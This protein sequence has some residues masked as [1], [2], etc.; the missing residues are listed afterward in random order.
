[1]TIL[2]GKAT[3]AS[4]KQ[5]LKVEIETLA[6]RF[7]RA[8]K[9]AAVLLGNDGASE[10]YVGAKVRSCKEIGIESLLIRESE[11]ISEDELLLIVNQLNTDDAVDGILV[12]LPLPKHINEERIT[13]AIAPIKDVDGFHPENLG[14]LVLGV[15]SY[16]PATPLGIMM[17][18]SQY[19]I[20]TE[21]MHAVVIGR[22]AIV[23]TP[24]SL[25]L[26]R[27][28][29]PGNCTVTLAHSR[30]KNL[31]ELTLQADLIIAALGK[32]EFLT[33]DM[34]KNGAVVIDV[35]ITRVED[36]SSSKGYVIKGDV[37]FTEVSPKCSYITPVPGGVGAMTIAALM[38]NTVHAFI[39]RNTTADI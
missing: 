30:T 31:K 18:L 35:G 22:S 16:T 24:M 6:E 13:L 4:V 20:N 8:P 32:P 27:N 7:G 33:A 12:Q 37:N 2:D 1:M 21:G 17:L 34:V 39:R 11:N 10:T 25:L 28:S 26:S 5:S 38:K 15:E 9:L 3:A 14:R 29:A 36:S 19:K 23:G